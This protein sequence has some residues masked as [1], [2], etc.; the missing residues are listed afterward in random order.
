MS[1]VREKMYRSF[2][3]CVVELSKTKINI[4]LGIFI[5]IQVKIAKFG[6]VPPT[7]SLFSL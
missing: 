1:K 4:I 7:V 5:E 6:S 2:E 3:E